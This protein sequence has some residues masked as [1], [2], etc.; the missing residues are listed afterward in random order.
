VRNGLLQVKDELLQVRNRLLQVKNGLL[1]VKNGLRNLKG[2]RWHT[3]PGSQT[4]ASTGNG[5]GK[6]EG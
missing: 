2:K 3:S 5:E 4:P 6:D 1:Q